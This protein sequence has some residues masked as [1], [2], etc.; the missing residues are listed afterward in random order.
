MAP[1][2]LFVTDIH[3][4]V[5]QLDALPSADLLLLGGDL[6][7]FGSVAQAEGVLRQFQDR[8][9]NVFAVSGNCD[10][11]GTDEMMATLD[12]DLHLRVRTALGL[13]LCGLG[14]CNKT[15]FSTPNEWI[16]EEMADRLAPLAEQLT[17]AGEPIVLVSHAPPLGSGAGRLP[18]GVDVGS[19]AVADFVRATRPAL[20]LCGHIHEAPGLFSLGDVPVVNPGPFSAGRFA[21]FDTTDL[22]PAIQSLTDGVATGE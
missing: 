13:R 5:K 9:A 10:A 1:T 18:N 4:A 7:H 8:F 12:C 3:G 2:V 15:P 16:E 14:G 17:A 11:A 6:T 22:A 19:Q 20:V 21:R